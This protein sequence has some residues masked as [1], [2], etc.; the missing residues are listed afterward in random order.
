MNI[1]KVWIIPPLLGAIIGYVTNWLAIKMLFRPLTEKRIFGLRV[2]FTPGLLPKERMR[3]S[4]GIGDTVANELITVDVIKERLADPQLKAAIE[5]E[6]EAKIDS[7]LASEASS[8]VSQISGA[9]DCPLG[10]L[11]GRAW[12]GFVHS[13]AFSAAVADAVRA[14]FVQA[15]K[16]P[17]SRLISPDDIRSLSLALLSDSNVEALKKKTV[18][19]LEKIY[20]DS[21]AQTGTPE[22]EGGTA[23]ADAGGWRKLEGILPPGSVEPLV[24]ALVEGLYRA[25][26]PVIENF[27]R[28]P[29]TK[30]NLEQYA[31]E[32]VRRVIS[33]LNGFQRFLIGVTQYEGTI[34]DSMPDTIE[35]LV[36]AASSMLR[37]PDMP[38]KAADAAVKALDSAKGGSPAS[39]LRGLI[40]H[41]AA[42]SAVDA[43]FGALKN[44]GPGVA[45]RA[46]NLL[47]S[48]PDFSLAGALEALGLSADELA[49][50]AKSGAG[51]FMDTSGA[52][53]EL[54]SIALTAFAAALPET[55]KG[56]QLGSIINLE[57]D[58]KKRLA[59]WLTDKGIDLISNE[60][61]SIIKGFDVS[62]VVV[63]KIDSLDMLDMER[64]IL[65]LADKELKWITVLGGVLGGLIG[66]LQ[67]LISL[68]P[69]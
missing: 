32:I 2:P 64:M 30:K 25:A 18:L 47:A 21:G 16:I 59:C 66:I 41:E 54:L 5:K 63:E 27:L 6:I 46:S 62:K 58:L 51:Q 55:L 33:R 26:I 39:A 53:G 20:A 40:S 37:Q 11:A 60:A 22:L 23:S 17:L 7:A 45:E 52:G 34:R 24:R 36:R 28:Q 43:A 49:S 31:N 50:R 10:E 65:G 38:G 3:I 42:L 4:K 9:S 56:Q 69:M 19:A 29:G 67:S 48:K 35:D 57:P 14:A 61:G 8:M 15:E 12:E 13:E 44:S 68:I 1:I